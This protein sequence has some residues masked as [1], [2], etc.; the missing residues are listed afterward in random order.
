MSCSITRACGKRCAHEPDEQR[1]TL[2]SAEGPN[3]GPIHRYIEVTGTARAEE[4]AREYYA[5]LDVEVRAAPKGGAGSTAIELRNAVVRMLRSSGM[6]DEELIEGGESMSRSW[7]R[8][9]AEREASHTIHL[10]C[11]TTLGWCVR[12]PRS[13][14]SRRTSER[15]RVCLSYSQLRWRNWAA[16]DLACRVSYSHELRE[17]RLSFA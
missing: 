4:T 7:W 17:K 10:K 9:K 14:R 1:H 3:H 16:P 12:W 11:T 15:C 8:R 5:R 6:R 13:S 2:S